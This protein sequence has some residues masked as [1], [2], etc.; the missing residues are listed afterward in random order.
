MV[1]E[2]KAYLGLIHQ[3][4]GDTAFIES[5]L[6]GG[7][8]NEAFVINNNGKKYVMYFPVG[9]SNKMV[10]R[11]QELEAQALCQK[12]GITRGCVHFNPVFGIKAFQFIEGDSIDHIQE[13]EI[14]YD[15]VAD[16]LIKLHE[17]PTDGFLAYNAHDRF[18][19]FASEL[20]EFDKFCAKPFFET[21]QL[22]EKKIIEYSSKYVA[23]CHNDAQ[24]SNIIRDS[25]GNY[26]IIDFE[27][28]MLNDPVYDIAAYGNNSVAEGLKLLEVYN[29]KK[30][31][32]DDY[33]IRYA[34]WRMYISMQWY[35]VAMLKHYRG[36]G[37]LTHFNFVEVANF[38][39]ANMND[40]R[41]LY[42][43]LVK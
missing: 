16:L 8:M 31:L 5:Q 23:L 22:V 41:K 4:F 40:A 25:N 26:F 29:K 3:V 24:R 35:V 6:H 9:E 42:D 32:G 27:F 19:V 33:K 10:D 12:A 13:A 21:A 43:V 17:L 2:N 1:E 18:N 37:E 28:A 14:D 36:E 7:M 38:F 15:K 39:L 20:Y 11:K 34:V 30:P